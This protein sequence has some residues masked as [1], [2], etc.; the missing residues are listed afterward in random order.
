MN[1]KV[2]TQWAPQMLFPVQKQHMELCQK[3]LTHY[4]KEGIVFLQW[5]IAIDETWVRNFEPELKS[6]SE[7]WKGKN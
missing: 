5:T 2:T 7:V 3:H 1:K 6:Q 4:E